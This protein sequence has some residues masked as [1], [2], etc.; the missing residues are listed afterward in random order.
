LKFET[1]FETL[2]MKFSNRIEV[3]KPVKII[4]ILSVIC[5]IWLLYSYND[6]SPAVLQSNTN[7]KT[8]NLGGG[9]DKQLEAPATPQP[10]PPSPRV[11]VDVYYECLC[12]D[13]RYF[14]LHQLMP[15]YK[16]V[17][18]LLDVRMWPYGKASSESTSDGF[19]FQCQHGQPECEGNIYHACVGEKVEDQDRMLEM[20]KCMIND[21]FQP[22]ES[23]RKCASHQSLDFSSIQTCATGREGEE[24]HYKAGLK[25][26]ALSPRVTFIPTIELDGSQHSQ[27]EILKN[28]HQEVCRVYSE[29]YLKPGQKMPNCP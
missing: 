25:T 27:K 18:S 6:R 12:P 29:K 1:E 7:L 5:L 22:E 19:S 16:K 14:V 26:E 3:T 11:V 20:I 24:L 23:A 28:F 4:G 2:I 13:S 10:P 9:D 21:N 8:S 17:G 15:A